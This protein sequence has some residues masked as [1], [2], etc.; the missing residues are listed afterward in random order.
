MVAP[1]PSAAEIIGKYQS[2]KDIPA[3]VKTAGDAVDKCVDAQKE[4]FD[5]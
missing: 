1:V 5:K 2:E 3:D 4:K